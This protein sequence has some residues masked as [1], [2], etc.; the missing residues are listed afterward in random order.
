MTLIFRSL[1]TAVM[2]LLAAGSRA[3]A[4]CPAWSNAPAQNGV[5]DEI[6]A[7]TVFDN[8]S[9]PALYAGGWFTQAGGGS[10]NHVAKWNGA[11]WS[12][13]G[14]GLSVPV[15]ALA[16]F[17]DGTGTALYAGGLQSGANPT[18]A[19]WN[20]AN[21]LPLGAGL[22][23]NVRALVVFDDGTGPA[24]YAG[25]D[26]SHAGSVSAPFIARWNGTSWSSLGGG[27]NGHVNALCVYDDGSGSALYAGGNFTTAG[28]ASASHI[29]KWNGVSWSALGTGTDGGGVYALAVFDDGGGPALCIGG[30]FSQ[31]NGAGAVG[32]AKW[33]GSIWTAMSEPN[34]PSTIVTFAVYDDGSGPALY[35][36]GYHAYLYR[37]NGTAWSGLSPSGVGDLGPASGPFALAAFDSGS[38]S[39]PALFIGGYFVTAGGI[40]SPYIAAWQ[41]CNRPGEKICAGDGSAGACPCAN[42]GAVGR[43]CN[44]SIATGGATVNSAGWTSLSHDSLVLTSSGELPSVLSVFLQGSTEIAPTSFGD[45]LRCAGGAL[46]RLYVKNAVAGTVTAPTSGD[47]SVSAR[48]AT[49]GDTI[50]VGET[51]VYQVYYRDPNLTFCPPPNGDAWNVSNGLRIAWLP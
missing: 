28:S 24:L 26:F 25:G 51:R 34:L 37:W 38:G 12:P 19:E 40:S 9:G 29:A 11:T 4:Q 30:N 35:A 47:A 10:A 22:D 50:Q 16:A 18:I 6:D 3:L 15:Q 21:W 42:N 20:G 27:M 1:P 17:D 46:K 2:I 23:N 31:V 5:S 8:G 7:L 36:G 39:G 43:G 45:G 13:L 48:S 49:L 44:N 32:A 33:N 14:S 41:G